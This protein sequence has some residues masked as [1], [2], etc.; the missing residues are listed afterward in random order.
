M[1]DGG[2]SGDS[3]GDSGDPPPLCADA[4]AVLDGTLAEAAADWGDHEG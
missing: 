2:D 4:D 3:G 1:G